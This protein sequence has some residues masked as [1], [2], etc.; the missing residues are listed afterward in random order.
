[1]SPSTGRCR[2]VIKERW[3][4]GWV[5]NS[6]TVRWLA[7]GKRF[8]WSSEK[9][10]FNQYYLYDL[11]GKLITQL[12]RGNFEAANIVDV[13]EK[14]NVMYYMMRDGDNFMMQQL[15]RVGLDGKTD[16]R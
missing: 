1:C 9:T 11:T 7:D 3:P 6:P 5:D 12:T 4:T 13:D 10:G 15:H 2:V 16:V 14:A 8:I